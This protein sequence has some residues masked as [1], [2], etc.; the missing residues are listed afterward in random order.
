MTYLGRNSLHAPHTRQR[1]RGARSSL[2]SLLPKAEPTPGR[3]AGATEHKGPDGY[4]WFG[5]G[6]EGRA[7]VSGVDD[8][9]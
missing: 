8:V 7:S 9:D 1:H 4:S 3:T 2:V 6:F 5:L